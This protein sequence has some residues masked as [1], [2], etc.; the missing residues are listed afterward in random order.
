MCVCVR[1]CVVCSERFMAE[2]P[3]VRVISEQ[4]RKHFS[5]EE[6]PE[7]RGERKG[8]CPH[9][10]RHGGGVVSSRAHL[11]LSDT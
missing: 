6:R 1:V 9:P 3:A 2:L 7:R 11:H 8:E 4:L 5:S 10:A